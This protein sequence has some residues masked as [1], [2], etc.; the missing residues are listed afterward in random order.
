MKEIYVGSQSVPV[1][2]TGFTAILYK[3]MLGKDLFSTL[4]DKTEDASKINDI[5]VL[6]YIMNLQAKNG[7]V[8]E[9][10]NTVSKEDGYYDFLNQF[11]SKDLYSPSVMTAIVTTW[12]QSTT[13][14]SEP[15]NA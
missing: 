5:L 4:T 12:I 1:K 14:S 15:K 13:T 9:M 11:E 6:F 3:R 8:G 2:A 7:T 10:L